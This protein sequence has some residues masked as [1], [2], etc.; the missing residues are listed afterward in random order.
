MKFKTI[1]AITVF[2]TSIVSSNAAIIEIDR[3]DATFTTSNLDL[4]AEWSNIDAAT[5]ISEALPSQTLIYKGSQFNNTIF[6]MTMEFTSSK[7][8]V[9]DLFAGLD[10]GRGAELYVNGNLVND[11]NT[12]LWWS[13]SWTNPQ[14]FTTNGININAGQNLVELFWAENGN[15]GGNSFLFSV[16]GSATKQLSTNALANSVPVPSM[17]TVFLLGAVGLMLRRRK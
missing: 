12:N 4:L 9:L 10:A 13:K 17:L 16:D 14:V 2:F 7:E 8:R 11:A 6:K 5:I 1:A 15:S 3:A